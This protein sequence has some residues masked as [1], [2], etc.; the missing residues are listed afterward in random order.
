[1]NAFTLMLIFTTGNALTSQVA[2]PEV[3]VPIPPP[4]VDMVLKWN[5]VALQAIR[6]ERSPPPVAARNLAILHCAIYDAVMAIE[7]TH[8]HALVDAIPQEAASAEAAAAAAAH[9]TLLGLYPRQREYFDLVL[10]R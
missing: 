10:G 2:A 8:H 7:R 4:R 6:E 3:R 5:E 1:M 9:R